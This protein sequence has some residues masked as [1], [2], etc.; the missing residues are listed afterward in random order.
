MKN[1]L[2]TAVLVL[3]LGLVMCQNVNAQKETKKFTAK[4]AIFIEARLNATRDAAGFSRIFHQSG[5]FKLS[6]SAGFSMRYYDGVLPTRWL[7]AIPMEASVLW[8]KSNHHLEMG[9]G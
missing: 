9:T 7:P 2:Q 1:I 4:N 8:G 5:A 3:F 6:Y